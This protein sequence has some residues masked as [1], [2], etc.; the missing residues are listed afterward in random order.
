MKSLLI[1]V[2]VAAFLALSLSIASGLLPDN[3]WPVF[4]AGLIWLSVLAAIA[5]ERR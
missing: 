3:M 1:F 5:Y 4:I 2:V